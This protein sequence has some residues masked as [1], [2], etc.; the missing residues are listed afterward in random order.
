MGGRC[1]QV[2]A[3]PPAVPRSW[4]L[5][6]SDIDEWVW[7][8]LPLPGGEPRAQQLEIQ[9]PLCLFMI[10]VPPIKNAGEGGREACLFSLC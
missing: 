3:M 7:S 4:P 1:K 9:L 6:E 10:V 2:L 8:A 5:F